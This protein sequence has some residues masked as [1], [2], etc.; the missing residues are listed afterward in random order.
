MSYFCAMEENMLVLTNVRRDQHGGIELNKNHSTNYNNSEDRS[1]LLV[2][3]LEKKL[4]LLSF[5][6]VLR[7]VNK[8]I[9]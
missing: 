4:K 8:N 6:R 5:E 3:S 7:G 2:I 9:M 1:T